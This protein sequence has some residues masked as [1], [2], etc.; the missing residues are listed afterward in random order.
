MAYS[1]GRD[2]SGN[3]VGANRDNM[4]DT[5]VGHRTRRACI[6]DTRR[7]GDQ[8]LIDNYWI[9]KA[10]SLTLPGKACLRWRTYASESPSFQKTRREDE[11]QRDPLLWKVD[12]EQIR[13]GPRFV[14]TK[15]YNYTTS[16]SE[17]RI[18]KGSNRYRYRSALPYSMQHFIDTEFQIIFESL[19]S[20]LNSTLVW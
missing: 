4:C 20:M 13:L 15:C 8:K 14:T 5:V 18:P 9:E 10:K 7:L 3:R 16:E 19:W 2:F 17:F 12:K 11:R 1:R 6:Y